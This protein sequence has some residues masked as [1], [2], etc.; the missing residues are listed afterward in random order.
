MAC[1][2]IGDPFAE[3]N[4]YE[5]S[6][7]VYSDLPFQCA[8]QIVVQYIFQWEVCKVRFLQLRDQ[9]LRHLILALMQHH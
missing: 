4:E 6:F 3:R 5:F 8:S 1:M 9:F 7:N 2:S